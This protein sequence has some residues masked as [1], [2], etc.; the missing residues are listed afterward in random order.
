MLYKARGTSET[1]AISFVVSRGG[2]DKLI[3][4]FWLKLKELTLSKNV[5]VAQPVEKKNLFLVF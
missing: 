2:G 4:S 3:Q 5:C 1:I